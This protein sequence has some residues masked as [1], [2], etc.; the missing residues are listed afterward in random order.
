[1]QRFTGSPPQ[2]FLRFFR[3]YCHPAMLDYIEGDLMEVYSVRMKE[4]G[5]RKADIKFII[6]VLLLFRPAIIKPI[7]DY[8]QSNTYSMYKSY[9]KIGWRNLVKNK[10]LFAINTTGLAIGIATCLTISMYIVGELSYDRYNEK[11]DQMVRVVL[12]GKLNGE[13]IKE[14]VTPAPVAEALKREFP[15]V[16][17]ATRLRNMGSPKIVY[18]NVTYRNSKVAFVDP[19]FFEVFT[20][21]LVKGNPKTVL[22]DP[23]AIVIT[24]EQAVKYFGDAD[25]INKI[26]E[27]K[28]SGEQY[29]VTGIMKK[30]PVNSHFHFD[31]FVSMAGLEDARN[32]NWLASQYFNYIVLSKGTS[33]T[34]FES[35]LP[36]IVNKYMG[37]QIPQMGMTYEKFQENGNQIGLFVQPLTDIHL[38]SDFAGSSKLEAGGDVKSIYIFGAVSLFMLLIACINFMNLSTAGASKR[39]KEVGIK[40]V[41]GSRRNQLVQQF[42]TESFISTSLAMI[43]G[44]VLFVLALPVFNHLSGKSYDESFLYN[45]RVII[46]LVIVGIGVS[47]FAGSYPAFF[48]SSIKP[49]AALKNKIVDGSKNIRIRSGLVVFQFVI[50]ACLILAIL[51]VNQQMSYIQNKDIGYDRDQLLVLRESY[52][53]GNEENAFRNKLLTD[54][55]IESITMSG[56]LPAGPTDNNMTPVYS[57]ENVEDVRRTLIYNI[58]AQYIPTMGMELMEGRNFSDLIK[59]DSLNIIVNETAVKTFGLGDNPLGKILTTNM[60]DAKRSFA[61]IGVVKDFH[62]RSLHE[63]IAPLM[64]FNNPYGGLIIKTKTTDIAGLISNIQDTWKSFNTDEPFSYALLDE[65]YNEAYLSEQNMGNILKIF[66]LLTIFV[67]C[68]GLYG[69]VTFTAEQRTKEI[70]IRKV[71]GAN[72]LEIVSLLSKEMLILVSISFVIAFPVGY[73]LMGKWLQNFNYRIDIHWWTFVVAAAITILIAFFTMSFKTITSAFANPIESLRSE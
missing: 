51:I 45:T 58:D 70:G 27:F 64:M 48:L 55:R 18:E 50:S 11:A 39:S 28:D 40:K 34:E 17:D 24:E 7:E 35:K 30:V 4:S 71:L 6:D 29:K 23:K 36:S 59:N 63:P 44:I 37:P 14:A 42:L 3:W 21:P 16:L 69:L 46:T 67:A 57:G 68:L 61:I 33:I 72:V 56:F 41:L 26:L 47:I 65:L 9:F 52:L 5:K 32:D 12:K 53:L 8:S 38:F 62:F 2:F 10:G 49:I 19:N 54:P 60:N 13:I 25:P 20:L 73:Y 1:M 31:L 66:G 43:L 15:E 22:Q